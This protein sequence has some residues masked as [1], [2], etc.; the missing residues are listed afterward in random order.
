VISAIAAE[1]ETHFAAFGA[2]ACI[3]KGPFDK[4]GGMFCPFWI[5]LKRSSVSA[6][7]RFGRCL[8]P[9]D[10]EGVALRQE[11]FEVILKG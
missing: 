3:A 1:E 11:T 2:N 4:M 6:L 8:S 10:Y 9:A 7:C 5:S